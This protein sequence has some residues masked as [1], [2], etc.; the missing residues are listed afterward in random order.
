MWNECECHSNAFIDSANLHQTDRGTQ[1]RRVDIWVDGAD[2]VTAINVLSVQVK[3][4]STI[5]K[6]MVPEFR[7]TRT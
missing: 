4:V 3:P 6:M 7:I 2:Y 5:C 1:G